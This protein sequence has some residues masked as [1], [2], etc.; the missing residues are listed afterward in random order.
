MPNKLLRC[1]VLSLVNVLGAGMAGQ[2]ETKTIA[3][4]G[5]G[6][7]ESQD[8]YRVLH[9]KGTP[10][11]MGYQQGTLLKEDCTALFKYLFEDKLNQTKIAYLGVKVPVRQAISG[12]F[13]VQRANIPDRYIEEMQGLADG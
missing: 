7:L 10:Y 5:A 3:R 11:E 13:T 6:F 12:I 1:A 2:A 8:G 9:L 4:C